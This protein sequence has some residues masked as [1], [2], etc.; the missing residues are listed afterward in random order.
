MKLLLIGGTGLISASVTALALREGHQVSLFNRG[1]N[2]D[3]AQRGAEYLVGDFNNAEERA[4]LLHGRDFDTVINFI[5]YTPAQV[6][7]D[8]DA[9]RGRAGQYVFISSASAYQKPVRNP[10]ITESTPLCNPYWQYSR[11]KIHGEELLTAAY[12]DDGFPM[13]I[14]RPSHTYAADKIP[15]PLGANGYTVLDRLRRGAPVI[16]PGDGT[17]L[18]TLTHADDVAVALLGLAGLRSAIGQAFHI[19]SDEA[20]T[21]NNIIRTVAEALGVTP[22]IVHIP[23]DTLIAM[24]PALEGPLLGDKAE[25]V[26]FDNSKIK[27]YVPWYQARI[28]FHTGVRM[29]LQYIQSH[30]ACQIIDEAYHREQDELASRWA[31]MTAGL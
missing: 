14:V 18:W 19:T 25:S 8:I 2:H 23:S 5:A 10:V 4:R 15:C 9:F 27:R 31:A 21:W 11:D 17:N 28:P 29:A 1:G 22:H 3:F 26:L 24:R 6:Q 16:V 12:R 20:L 7:S 30:P 13:T